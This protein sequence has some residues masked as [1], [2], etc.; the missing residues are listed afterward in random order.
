M[1]VYVDALF[2]SPS[3]NTQA[4]TIGT[5]TGHKWC[6]LFTDGYI[7]ELHQFAE[8]LGLKRNWFQHHR[9][10][11]HYDIAPS[12]RALALRLGAIEADSKK[13]YNVMQEWK[14]RNV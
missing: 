1:T 11:P 12:K 6:H 3:K 2:T 5:R 4:Y 13:T 7:E 10:L 9:A 14:K 8:G